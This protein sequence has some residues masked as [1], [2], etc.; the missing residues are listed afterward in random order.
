MQPV[1]EPATAAL[2]VYD[3]F[4][5]AGGF[6]L[7]AHQAGFETALAVDIDQTLAG[8]IKRNRPE[9]R[10][11]KIDLAAAEAKSLT[12]AAAGQLPDGIIGGPPCQGFSEIGR[13]QA[14]D[15]RNALL[16]HFYRLVADLN[17]AFFVME[18]VR[19]ILSRHGR[20]MLDKGI[21]IVSSG[22]RV[23]Q[24][25][26]IQA[27]DFGV[28]TTRPRVLVVGFRKDL[29]ITPSED[30]FASSNAPRHNVKDAIADLQQAT[31]CGKDPDEFDL[32]KYANAAKIGSLAWASRNKDEAQLSS[33]TG[34]GK[35]AHSE[36]VIKRYTSVEQGSTDRIGRHP[37][38]AWDG[39]CPTLRAGTGSD[40]GSYQSVRPLHPSEPRV[41][42]V[43]E[44][45]R[46][47]G[48][49][50][51]YRFHPTMWHSCRM[52]GNSVPPPVALGVLT[53]VASL[54]KKA[55]YGA[56]LDDGA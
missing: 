28:A 52:I 35:V 11:Q 16:G 9:A 43:R 45:A 7:G 53:E 1:D 24:P 54:L 47:Q 39:L 18:N 32:W 42:T 22:Y 26:L 44:A 50:D 19:G 31:S 33:F 15:P 8:A 5:G 37:R 29:G 13:G 49:P 23:T 25:I 17:P 46:L 36:A 30:S 12:E 40:R 41:I 34:H 3:L 56:K 10:F 4:C 2:K 55:G 14:D 38:L 20:E 27:N 21:G 51:W 6:S 48:F